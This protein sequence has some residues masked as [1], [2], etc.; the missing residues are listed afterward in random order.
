MNLARENAFLRSVSNPDL[1]SDQVEN[2][3]VHLVFVDEIQRML[4]LH[5]I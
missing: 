3:E 5:T 4:L 2:K 1:F